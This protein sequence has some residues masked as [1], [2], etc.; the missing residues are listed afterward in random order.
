[1]QHIVKELSKIQE[2]CV[3]DGELY[4]EELGSFQEQMRAIKKPGPN[5]SKINFNVYDII[6]KEKY[7]HR[8]NILKKLLS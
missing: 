3:L 8:Q 7:E 6:S 5:S 1:M 4:S 2:N